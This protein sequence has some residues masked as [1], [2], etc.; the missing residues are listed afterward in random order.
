M[1]F[2][3]L[4]IRNWPIG[5]T[6]L[7]QSIA[8]WQKMLKKISRI[9]SELYL[10]IISK[11]VTF[12]L[13]LNFSKLS[14]TFDQPWISCASQIVLNDDTFFPLMK[15][16]ALKLNLPILVLQLWPFFNLN[17]SHRRKRTGKLNKILPF[18]GLLLHTEFMI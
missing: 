15:Y 2:F 5:S 10:F 16:Y 9:I 4:P 14:K 18:S 3:V 13:V 12:S 7:V 1:H 8:R 11:I 6:R 17:Q